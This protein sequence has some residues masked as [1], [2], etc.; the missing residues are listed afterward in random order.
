MF[1]VEFAGKDP[2]AVLDLGKIV[3][4][5][6]YVLRAFRIK[7]HC[8]NEINIWL[9]SDRGEEIHFQHSNENLGDRDVMA[10]DGSEDSCNELFNTI[11]WVDSVSLDGGAEMR[12]VMVYLPRSRATRF[13]GIEAVTHA[14]KGSLNFK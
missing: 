8:E 3:D 12:L 6:N 1:S 9:G 4:N 11:G 5:G 7:N 14:L 2:G 13:D 10:S